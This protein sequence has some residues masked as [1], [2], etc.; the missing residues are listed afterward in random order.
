MIAM[1]TSRPSKACA[2]P[3][4]EHGCAKG[5]ATHALVLPFDP[6]QLLTAHAAL[7]PR[8]RLQDAHMVQL[9]SGDRLPV[10]LL[11]HH[12]GL[13]E[14]F[15]HGWNG[16]KWAVSRQWVVWRIMAHD[17]HHGGELALMLGMQGIEAFELQALGGHLTLP[18][19]AIQPER[20]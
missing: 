20:P 2:T 19:K 10:A 3:I 5:V 12:R 18:Q 13:G 1:T 17:I 14:T 6:A 11:L 15:L 9:R 16:E 4:S 8:Q 7:V